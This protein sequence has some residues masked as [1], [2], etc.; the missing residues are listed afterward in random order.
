[1]GLSCLDCPD[2]VASPYQNTEYY[3]TVNYGKNCTVTTST[4]V[5][6]GPGASVYIP[7][8]FTPN[9]DGVNDVFSV[10]GTTLQSVSMQI[11]DRWGE[12]V[13]D[14]GDSQWASWDGAYR[15]V[16]EAPGV[17]IYYVQLVYLD[18]KQEARQGSL[19]LIR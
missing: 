10:F 11:F 3:L 6:I 5:Q 16:M 18:G 2:P 1:V 15:G 19:T 7:N 9:G 8:A 17:Y 13:F 4:I 14:S 12:K